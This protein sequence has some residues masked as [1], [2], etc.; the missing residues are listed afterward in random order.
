MIPNS[1]FDKCSELTWSNGA[2]NE[3]ISI[4]NAFL[5]IQC[6]N[7]SP[8]F[9]NNAISKTCIRDECVYYGPRLYFAPTAL[10]YV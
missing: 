8:G 5:G 9:L 10:R 4:Y 1:E 6:P 7:L 2:M 3:Y